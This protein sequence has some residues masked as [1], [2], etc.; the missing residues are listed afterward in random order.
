[1]EERIIDDEEG[2]LIKIKR[3]KKGVDVVE[4]AIEEKNENALPVEPLSQSDE[5]ALQEQEVADFLVEFQDDEDYDE[6]LVGLTP[7]QIKEELERRE[8]A[9]REAKENCEKL[10]ASGKELLKEEKF[11]EAAEELSAAILYDNNNEEAHILLWQARTKNYTDDEAYYDE[12]NAEELTR[13]PQTA[14]EEI[15]SHDG[16]RLKAERLRLQEEIKPLKEKVFGVQR[17]RREPLTANKNYYRLRLLILL[18]LMVVFGIAA[19]VSGYF[20]VRTLS[21]APVVLAAVFGAGAFACLVAA[22]VYTRFYLEAVRLYR[23]NEDTYSTEEGRQLMDM[24]VREGCLQLVLEGKAKEETQ[25]DQ[26]EE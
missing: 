6:N 18:G 15:L 25:T 4:D 22:L 14:R 7:S 8:R 9:Q 24:I 5:E 11:D 21:I 26:S 19:G 17:E 10:V 16:E 20:T 2:R 13:A 1:M 12:D 3:T 23:I